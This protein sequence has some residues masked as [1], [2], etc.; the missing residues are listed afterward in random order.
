[1]VPGIGMQIQKKGDDL[2]VDFNPYVGYRFTGRITA[3]PGWN[4]RLAYNTDQR[5]FNREARIFGPRIFGEFKLG[6]GFSPRAEIEVMNTKI[7]PSTYTPAT[8]PRNRQWVWGAFIGIKK[9]YKFFK[10]V[11]GT[12]SIMT[13]LY[14]PHHK[15]PYA[16]VLNMRFGFEFPMKKKSAS[17]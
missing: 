17:K 2:L 8:D 4:Q 5:G 3:G 11:K 12:A 6:K 7:P 13:R 1:M 16:D 9:E 14:N 15:S 10:H